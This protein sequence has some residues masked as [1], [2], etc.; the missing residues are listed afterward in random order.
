VVFHHLVVENREVKSKSELDGITGWQL[1][2]VSFVVGFERVLLDFL[3]LRIL[4]V[5]SDVAIVVTNHLHKKCFGLTF[6]VLGKDFLVN[7][8]NNFLAVSG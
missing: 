6:A 1:N 4:G 8:I 7:H 2:L 3:K 5:F